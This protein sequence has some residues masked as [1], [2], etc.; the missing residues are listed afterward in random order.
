[1]PDNVVS[2]SCLASVAEGAVLAWN[3]EGE[4]V[5]MLDLDELG[6]LGDVRFVRGSLGSCNV[7]ERLLD[8][9]ARE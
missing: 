9:G 6:P 7:V 8:R 2:T 3:A 5:G 1:V 4:V